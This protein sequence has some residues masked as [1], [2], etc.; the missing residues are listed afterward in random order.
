MGELSFKWA[1]F[2]TQSGG[3]QLEN[4]KR[5]NYCLQN[6]NSNVYRKLS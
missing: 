3:T 1:G 4:N 5:E 6:R 2:P